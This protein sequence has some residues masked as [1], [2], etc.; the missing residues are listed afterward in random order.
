MGEEELDESVFCLSYFSKGRLNP[1]WVEQLGYRRRVWYME[2]LHS[3]LSKE[4]AQMEKME[5]KFKG[6]K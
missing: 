3:Q 5:K 6:R 4:V 2:R 1:E